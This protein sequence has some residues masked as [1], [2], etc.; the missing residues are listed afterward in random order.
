MQIYCPINKN[1]D[2]AERVP[3]AEAE[4]PSSFML[5]VID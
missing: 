1:R 5:H 4:D 2:F 3:G